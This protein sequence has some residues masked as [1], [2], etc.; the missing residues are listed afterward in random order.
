MISKEGSTNIVNLVLGRGHTYKSYI[1]KMLNFFFKT[2]SLDLLLSRNEYI[3]MVIKEG[4]TKIVSFMAPGARAC[5]VV[6]IAKC[7]FHDPWGGFAVLSWC[8]HLG[9]IMKNDY[10]LNNL[11]YC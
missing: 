4:S 3:V 2:S 9:D 5:N 1:E 6:K 7:K 11:L 8:G 10:F